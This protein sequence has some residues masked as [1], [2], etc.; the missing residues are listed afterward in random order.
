MKTIEYT[1]LDSV[2]IFVKHSAYNFV[3]DSVRNLVSLRLWSSVSS[4]VQGIVWH[5]TSK[6][7]EKSIWLKIGEFSM[8]EL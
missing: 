2:E 6:P 8:N 3:H 4:S 7:V 5:S 1:V